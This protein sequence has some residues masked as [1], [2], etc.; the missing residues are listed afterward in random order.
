M[1]I[2]RDA[3][4]TKVEARSNFFLPSIPEVSTE[5]LPVFERNG[6][7]IF[8]PSETPPVP[9]YWIFD[10]ITG[11]GRWVKFYTSGTGSTPTLTSTGD[12]IP[13]V[14]SG[15][16]PNFQIANLAAG[17]NMSLVPDGSGALE[18]TSTAVTPTTITSVGGGVSVLGPS[19]AAIP[20]ALNPT[21]TIKS[22]FGVNGVSIDSSVPG[23][24]TI[25]FAA[26]GPTPA[27]TLTSVGSGT[28]MIFTGTGPV[29]RIKNLIG[30]GGV[31]IDSTDPEKLVLF[32]GPP[33]YSALNI[34]PLGTGE[35]L[36]VDG[37]SPNFSIKGLVAGTAMTLTSNATTVTLSNNV[38]FGEA[39]STGLSLISTN[40]DVTNFRIINP[41]FE[42][43][44]VEETASSVTV[45][46]P[47]FFIYTANFGLSYGFSIRYFVN[48]YSPIY[49]GNTNI[50]DTTR[51]SATELNVIVRGDIVPSAI[52]FDVDVVTTLYISFPDSYAD[53]LMPV[54]SVQFWPVVL[55]GA[56]QY[57]LAFPSVG[58]KPLNPNVGANPS[59]VL[60]TSG[61]SPAFHTWTIDPKGGAWRCS[62]RY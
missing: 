19:S 27:V 62:M 48:S 16:S 42:N 9:K 47:S 51:P 46:F 34:S 30:A 57:E 60:A 36:I 52:D 26:S 24:L 10:E 2:F 56:G 6:A 17:T 1:K 45:R 39:S 4:A 23:I 28:S 43:S 31:T 55:N 32:A 61:V 7:M 40:S 5:N 33:D 50:S 44:Y 49:D 25:N 3:P 15:S 54:P 58:C 12:G 53:S 29:L 20:P 18:I 13:I 11:T 8:D 14:V 22:L 21:Y 37:T 59:M 41:S 35:S 38:N